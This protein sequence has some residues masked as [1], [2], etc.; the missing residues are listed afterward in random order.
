MKANEL[1]DKMNGY[2]LDDCI[3]NA[4]ICVDRNIEMFT[5][6]VNR[7]GGFSNESRQV[8]WQLIEN[9]SKIKEELL[10]RLPY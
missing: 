5:E 2:T 7:M 8:I 9:E 10:E 4:I 3:N 1:V 6:L